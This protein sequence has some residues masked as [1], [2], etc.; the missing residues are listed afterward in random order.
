MSL[1]RLA[2]RNAWHHRFRTTLTVLA[3]AVAITAYI[4]LQTVLTAWSTLAAEAAEDRITTRNDVSLAIQ[5][6]VHYGAS[7]RQTP[8]VAA[9]TWINWFG[10]RYPAE[11]H[12]FFASFAVDADSFFEVYREIE[13]PPEQLQSWREDRQGAVVGD[14]LA[15]RLGLRVGDTVTLSGTMHGGDWSFHVAGIYTTTR[16]SV[17]RSQFLLRWDYLNERAGGWARDRIGWIAA[18]VDDPARSAEVASAIDARFAS[19]DFRTVT[20]SER[21]FQQSLVT[22]AGEAL[23]ALDVISI[24]VIAIL[25]LVVANTIAMNVRERAHEHGALRAIG[26]G[27]RAIVA[28]VVGEAFVTALL[29]AAIGLALCYPVVDRALGRWIE[30]NSGSVLPY[31]RIELRTLATAALLA[32]SAPSL[33]A[34]IPAWLAARKRPTELLR[35]VG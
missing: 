33:A 21:A 26:F 30:E 12:V 6:P 23:D 27:P 7:V 35:Q 25:A 2:A 13:L 20:M 15:R 8:G 10:G 19:R 28:L 4:A 31:F 22:M 32:V 17:D 34:A 18:R 3:G 11:P 24:I 29:G 1:F 9:A 16:R 5:L 14:A